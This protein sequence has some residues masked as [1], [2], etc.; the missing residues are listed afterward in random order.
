MIRLTKI[1]REIATQVVEAEVGGEKITYT[2]PDG[3]QREVLAKTVARAGDQH[4]A[5]AQYQ[6]MVQAKKQQSG[7]APHAPNAQAPQAQAP[8]TQTPRPQ[9]SQEKLEDIQSMIDSWVPNMKDI[10]RIPDAKMQFRTALV[11]TAVALPDDSDFSTVFNDKNLRGF[12]QQIL[13]SSYTMQSILQKMAD[14]REVPVDSVADEFLTGEINFGETPWMTRIARQ[15]L[16]DALNTHIEVARVGG[17]GLF[18][19][20]LIK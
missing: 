19:A 1:L 20:H 7:Q 6:Q 17:Q 4:P 14:S 2:T 11:A 3:K 15:G 8:T 10:E 12:R 9:A 18:A 13:H 5:W 16:M